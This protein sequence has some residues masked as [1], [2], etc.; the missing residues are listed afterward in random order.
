MK[1]PHIHAEF[2]K[3]WA[4]GEE[5]EY[6]DKHKGAWEDA[7]RPTWKIENTYRIKPKKASYYL[8]LDDIDLNLPT[9]SLELFKTSS[10]TVSPD[11]RRIIKITFDNETLKSEVIRNIP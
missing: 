8:V 1:S 4:D 5:I 3:A 9:Q 6:F 10:F 2:I 11:S 7:E